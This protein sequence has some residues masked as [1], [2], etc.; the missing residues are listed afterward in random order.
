[1]SVTAAA[2]RK[3]SYE[4]RT[5]SRRLR[6]SGT[7]EG[8]W[9]ALYVRPQTGDE[10]GTQRDSKKREEDENKAPGT[11]GRITTQRRAG[12]WRKKQV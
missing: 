3:G 4:E 9:T 1:M 8:S 12:C 7:G 10:R 5:V 6:A 11:V 2:T